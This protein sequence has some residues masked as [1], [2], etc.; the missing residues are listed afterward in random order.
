[1]TRR[2][3]WLHISDIHFLPKNE[4]RD[5]ESRS[6]L[7]T[8]L[9]RVFEESPQLRPDLIFCTGDIA[10]GE[11]SRNTL[12]EQYTDAKTF[13]DLLLNVCG[14]DDKPLLKERLFVV[15]GNHDI[16]RKSINSDAQRTLVTKAEDSHRY[17]NE[18]NDRFSNKSIE[19]IDAIKRQDEYSR[20]LVEYLPHQVD[21]N[22]RNVYQ[23]RLNIGE[24]AVEIFG[25]NSAWTA[26]GPE[27]D[28]NLWLAAL[29]QFSLASREFKEADIR[30]GLIHHPAEWL[31][32]AD[33]KVTISRI[34]ADYDFW[35]HGHSHDTWVT[36]TSTNVTIGAGAI[37][38]DSTD[39][40]GANITFADLDAGR[41]AS[42]LYFK[43]MSSTGWTI[44]P[45]HEHAPRGIWEYQL[46]KRTSSRPKVGMAGDLCTRS[47]NIIDA[48]R[49]ATDKARAL[50]IT[51]KLT[52]DLDNC[53]RSYSSQPIIWVEPIVSRQPETAKPS[54][55]SEQI[56]V[57]EIISK[58]FNRIIVAAPQFGLTCLLRHLSLRAWRDF[59]QLWLYIDLEEIKPNKAAIIQAINE[60]L[61]RLNAT[62]AEP[63]CLVIDGG[64]DSKEFLKS[65]KILNDIFPHVLMVCAY[66]RSGVIDLVPRELSEVREFQTAYLWP[67]SRSQIRHVVASY[68]RERY[69]GEEDVVTA[70]LSSDLEVLNLHRTPLNCLTLLKVSEVDFDENPVNRS[71]MIKRI[72]FIIFNVDSIPTYKNRPD[73]K[74][75]E[76]VLGYFCQQLIER[77]KYQFSRSQFLSEIQ[78]FCQQQLIDLEIHVVFDVLYTNNIIVS[79]GSQF[80]FKFS[81]WILYFAAQRMHHDASFATYVLS[82][83][84][85]AQYPEIIEFY[86]GIDR[87]RDGAL[88]LITSDL[89]DAVQAVKRTC[90]LPDDF[91][92]YRLDIWKTTTVGE[93]AMQKAVAEGVKE[94]T[95]PDEIKDK[96]AD[97]NY[98]HSRPYNQN[99]EKFLKQFTV[100]SLFKLIQAAAR[101]LRNSDYASPEVKRALLSAIL[102]AWEQF[103]RVILVILPVL[104][105]EGVAT[106]DG[107]NFKVHGSEGEAPDKIAL[108]ILKAIPSNIIDWFEGDVYSQKMSPLLL[109][110]VSNPDASDLSRHELALLIIRR[111]PRNWERTVHKYIS[112]VRK[113]S[114]Y[115]LNTFNA[116]RLQY[117]YGYASPLVL[118]ELEHLIKMAATKHLTGDKEPGVK[119]IGKVK[120]GANIL[121]ERG[122]PPIGT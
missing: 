97:A 5:N 104:S 89:L 96:F 54:L 51:K 81:Y 8:H 60:Q 110:R 91:N 38:A 39:E 59:G 103:S 79:I 48:Q 2:L 105:T 6:S 50:S 11:T 77:D 120:F 88:K 63:A 100:A 27:D 3:T 86:T 82:D 111:R 47:G 30:I 109:E 68:N 114:F 1:M 29:S 36:P 70:R 90:G 20:F 61:A 32:L 37:G 73:L 85:Y 52:E 84:R 31:A 98:D 43:A 113:D 42:H 28:R 45:I 93:Q 106:F 22:G 23:K 76:F 10:F 13:F 112:S 18:V 17:V 4:W 92:P 87:K 64:S 44:H 55:V 72:L 66:H 67:L 9:K 116:L 71:E 69:I 21:I 7:L 101:A 40:F 115:L 118:R 99:F 34:Q 49:S 14:P 35:L 102:S 57:D 62:I 26:S 56:D 16:N 74:D 15:P 46:P 41:G 53:L 25:F 78:S 75:C 117:S 121:P 65:I 107:E 80:G 24:V 12:S 58:P 19:F 108:A 119:A 95:L 33:R 83:I 122:D 94:S